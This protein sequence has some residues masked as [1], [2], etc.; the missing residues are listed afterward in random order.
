MKID[1]LQ[2]AT[3]CRYTYPKGQP[4]SRGGVPYNRVP[5]GAEVP[6]QESFNFP[7][8]FPIET[9]PDAKIA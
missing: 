3:G 7:D 9:D 8:I 6:S 4:G 2:N 5:E 1:N